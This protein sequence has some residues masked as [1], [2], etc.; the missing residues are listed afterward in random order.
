MNIFYAPPDHISDEKIQIKGEEAHHISRVL[1]YKIGQEIIVV[2]GIGHK[3]SGIIES[4]HK[5]QVII[6]ITGKKTLVNP[7]TLS[8]RLVLGMGII[9]NRQRLEFAVEKAIELGASEIVLFKSRYTEKGNIRKDRLESIM[10]SAMKQSMHAVLPVIRMEESLQEVIQIYKNYQIVIAHEK[11][12][13][14]SGI[15]KELNTPKKL[16]L[17]VGPEGGFSE[18]EVEMVE[19]AGGIVVSLGPYRLRA[20]TAA[21]TMMAL[22][23]MKNV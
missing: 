3:Y 11:F 16:L 22:F 23:S 13:G 18:E 8:Q 19:K 6:K 12:E 9:K 20:E 7:E 14:P 2:D 1:R 4:I 10:I 17:L 5:K 15:P 21:I